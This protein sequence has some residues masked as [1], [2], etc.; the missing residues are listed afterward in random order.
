MLTIST[1]TS[2]SSW[3]LTWVLRLGALLLSIALGCQPY[4]HRMHL[5]CHRLR[6]KLV[7]TPKEVGE[8]Q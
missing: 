8:S 6:R 4:V 3:L 7:Q 2:D 5:R 1:G